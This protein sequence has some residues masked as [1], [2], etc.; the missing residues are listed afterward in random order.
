MPYR[1][2][3]PPRGRPRKAKWVNATKT[4]PNLTP[5]Q[6]K[7]L[8]IEF[9]RLSDDIFIGRQS[10]RFKRPFPSSLSAGQIA[11]HVRVSR[12]MIQ[13]WRNDLR[14]Q[15][16]LIYL[17]S[18]V[19]CE[20]LDRREKNAATELKL[21]STRYGEMR[22]KVRRE[23]PSTGSVRSYADEKYYTDPDEY[24]GNLYQLGY[25]FVD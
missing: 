13:R 11:K 15:D 12:Q 25:V 1:L 19:I 16:G 24:N 21:S 18:Q 4:K 6:W 8:K 7:A 10:L 17:F 23:W 3:G 14:Y 2:T 5:K 9:P 20:R 22:K